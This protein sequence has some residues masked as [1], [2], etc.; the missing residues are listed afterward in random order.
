M[1]EGENLIVLKIGHGLS[2]YYPNGMFLSYYDHVYHIKLVIDY[3]KWKKIT[4]MGHR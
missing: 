4:I 3:F 1:K 2:P